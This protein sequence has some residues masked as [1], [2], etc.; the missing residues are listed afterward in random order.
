[1]GKIFE[2]LT[3]E[4]ASA[5]NIPHKFGFFLTEY[6]NDTDHRIIRYIRKIRFKRPNPTRATFRNRSMSSTR[7]D[8]FSIRSYSNYEYR[9]FDRRSIYLS[10]STFR[11]N[12]INS[13]YSDYDNDDDDQDEDKFY[14]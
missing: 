6:L 2:K 5:R 12:S 7:C 13:Y 10:K 4:K 9:N 11:L 3:F 8:S 14:N 1:M